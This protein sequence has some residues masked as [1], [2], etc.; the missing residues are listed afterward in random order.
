MR[1]TSQQLSIISL[2][3]GQIRKEERHVPLFFFR[4]FF[5]FFW[6]K[7]FQVRTFFLVYSLRLLPI[8]NLYAIICEG[9]NICIH[10]VY[11]SLRRDVKLKIYN[12]SQPLLSCWWGGING[13]YNKIATKQRELVAGT[14]RGSVL[15]YSSA[16][17]RPDFFEV[18][19]VR[20]LYG[21]GSI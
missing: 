16:V 17:W 18:A 5:C 7:G 8:T 2:I 3:R 14:I 10:I 4:L 9:W 19:Q 15:F 12:P 1:L 6:R 13:H 11:W 21:V 20:Y